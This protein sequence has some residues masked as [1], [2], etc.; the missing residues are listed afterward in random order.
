MRHRLTL[1]FSNPAA[2]PISLDAPNTVSIRLDGRNLIEFAAF[3]PETL[4]FIDDGGFAATFDVQYWWP[5][6]PYMLL[7]EG[8]TVDVSAGPMLDRLQLLGQAI[9]TER[10][11]VAATRSDWKTEPPNPDERL[12]LDYTRALTLPE[13]RWLTLGKTPITMEDKWFIFFEDGSLY[14]HRSWIG[15]P[16]FEVEMSENAITRAWYYPRPDTDIDAPSV[17]ASLIEGRCEDARIVLG[18]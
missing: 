9:V 6:P 12:D 10:W 15:F 17:V 7:S 3:L 2:S 18:P 5:I 4:R 13:Y 1:Q 8:T 16:V 11:E 14:F